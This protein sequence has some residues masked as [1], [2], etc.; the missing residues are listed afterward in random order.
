M[1]RGTHAGREDEAV[2]E[3]DS[4]QYLANELEVEARSGHEVMLEAMEEPEPEP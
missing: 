3:F 4:C 1:A 2:H